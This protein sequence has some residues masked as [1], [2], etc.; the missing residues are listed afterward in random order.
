LVISLGEPGGRRIRY[1]SYLGW[2]MTSSNRN[3]GSPSVRRLGR[4]IAQEASVGAFEDDLLAVAQGSG[5]A[6]RPCVSVQ[7]LRHLARGVA[8][9]LPTRWRK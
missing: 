3:I 8:H 2:W 5:R 7:R 4:T 9:R 6:I 1:S